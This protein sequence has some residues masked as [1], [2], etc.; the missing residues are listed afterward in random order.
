MLQRNGARA[1]SCDRTT[2]LPVL[3][4]VVVK[5]VRSPPLSLSV[6]LS[7]CPSPFSLCH[8][9]AR[10]RVHSFSRSP[11][12][13]GPS[14]RRRPV[15]QETAVVGF[16]RRRYKARKERSDTLRQISILCCERL[17]GVVLLVCCYGRLGYGITD[18]VTIRSVF[19]ARSA[20]N[21]FSTA[22]SIL[23]APFKSA[24][25]RFV[26]IRDQ[27]ITREVFSMTGNSRR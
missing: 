18:R 25:V 22:I 5:R 3:V 10:T 12:L 23:F 9:R 19:D 7:L 11:S 21:G 13:L 16:A 24:R 6:S 4:V 15:T 27:R 2:C 17:A 26:P 14:V 20:T 1:H 8:T